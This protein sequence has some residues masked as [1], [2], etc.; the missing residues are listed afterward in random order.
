MSPLYDSEG[1]AV[2]EVMTAEE[3]Q[4]KID[5]INSENQKKVDD[6][7]A[8]ITKRDEDLNNLPD[9]DKNFEKLRKLKE[10]AEDKL[11]ELETKMGER[12]D[13]V[14]KEFSEKSLTLAIKQFAGEDKDLFTKI[15]NNYDN[16]KGE[17]AN[18]AEMEQRVK[19]AATLAG[20]GVGAGRTS[21]EGALRGGGGLPNIMDS[22]GKMGKLENQES[23]EVARSLGIT[24]DDLKKHGLI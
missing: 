13:G 19:N 21:I 15:K 10:T 14:R 17:P 3:V 24:D 4:E 9:R 5:A 12:I 2:E 22:S 20:V 16:F 1:N 11:K 18:E 6:L 23:K 8:E 7:Q